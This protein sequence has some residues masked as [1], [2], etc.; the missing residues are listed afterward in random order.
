MNFDGIGGTLGKICIS[1]FALFST[2]F[3]A[4]AY[5]PEFGGDIHMDN[6]EVWTINSTLGTSTFFLYDLI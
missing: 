6:S 3:V 5:F 2:S 1:F 4:H